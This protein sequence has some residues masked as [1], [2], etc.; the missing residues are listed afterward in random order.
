MRTLWHTKIWQ[1][2]KGKPKLTWPRLSFGPAISI[3]QIKA[4]KSFKKA[5]SGVEGFRPRHAGLLSEACLGCLCK[6]LAVSEAWGDQPQESSFVMVKMLEKPTGGRRTICLF[7]T[8]A[9]LWCKARKD[10]IRVWM[11]KTVANMPEI[12]MQAGRVVGD[13]VYRSLLRNEIAAS[14]SMCAAELA[15]DVQ[16]CYEH[17]VWKYLQLEGNLMNFPVEVLASIVSSYA[18]GRRLTWDKK[19]CVLAS[20]SGYCTWQWVCLL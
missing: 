14:K 16:K 3:G 11:S 19:H 8:L 9:R 10:K 5:T 18:W 13:I 15:W 1:T 6:I 20:N 17:V 7:P 12:N 2:K 4:A